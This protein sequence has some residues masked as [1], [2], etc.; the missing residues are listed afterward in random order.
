MANARLKTADD[1]TKQPLVILSVFAA[2]KKGS[3]IVAIYFSAAASSQRGLH[4]APRRRG[5]TR[6]AAASGH[7]G[8]GERQPGGEVQHGEQHE[9]DHVGEAEKNHGV[10]QQGGQAAARA[11]ACE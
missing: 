11:P 10:A 8:L 9:A 3:A 2:A 1:K 4:Y 6:R 5:A 7:Q